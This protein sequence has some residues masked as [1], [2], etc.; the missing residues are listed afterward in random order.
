M[1]LGVPHI[2]MPVGLD[3]L[4]LFGIGLFLLGLAFGVAHHIF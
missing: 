3:I 4:R 2:V 1:I